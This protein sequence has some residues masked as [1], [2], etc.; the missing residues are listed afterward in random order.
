MLNNDRILYNKINFTLISFLLNLY[1]LP[2]LEIRLTT[3]SKLFSM[4][5]THIHITNNKFVFLFT[6]LNFSM[7]DNLASSNLVSLSNKLVIY[8]VSK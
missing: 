1:I 8:Y 6:V 7:L 3:Y 5:K 4:H 2:I